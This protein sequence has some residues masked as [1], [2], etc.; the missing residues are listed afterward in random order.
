MLLTFHIPLPLLYISCIYK[1]CSCFLHSVFIS[2]CM[3]FLPEISLMIDSLSSPEI[4]ST[5]TLRYLHFLTDQHIEDLIEI[6]IWSLSNLVWQ[7]ISAMEDR[8]RNPASFCV[9]FPVT[10]SIP[11]VLYLRWATDKITL[12]HFNV[13]EVSRKT[14]SAF[15][16]TWIGNQVQGKLFIYK[17]LPGDFCALNT[18]LC[19]LWKPV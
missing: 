18:E 4:S 5:T 15:S 16:E 13:A 6:K 7:P 2:F 8:G 11:G 3:Q 10:H 1:N 17:H 9:L 14:A 19:R 12:S